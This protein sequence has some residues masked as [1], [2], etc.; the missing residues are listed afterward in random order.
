[1]SK[2]WCLFRNMPELVLVSSCTFSP[3]STT[4][5]FSSL[6]LAYIHQNTI[7]YVPQRGQKN[8]NNN[9]KRK[10]LGQGNINYQR[11]EMVAFFMW[12]EPFVQKNSAINTH[13][14]QEE[15]GSPQ[16]HPQATPGLATPQAALQG[17]TTCGA[18]GSGVVRGW[19]WRDLDSIKNSNQTGI[20]TLSRTQ[21]KPNHQKK[22]YYE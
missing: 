4:I 10:K 17:A 14:Y 13:Q 6:S 11:D 5:D 3:S 1:M 12:E 18:T 21:I 15:C 7:K 19:L 8:K 2:T 16:N 22:I 9:N 20:R